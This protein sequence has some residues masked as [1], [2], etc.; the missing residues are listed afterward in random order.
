[1]GTPDFAVPTLE[2]LADSRHTV[3]AAVTNPDRPKGRGRK[4]AAPPVKERA[5]ALDIPVIQHNSVNDEQLHAELTALA[6]DLFVVVA[7][8]ILPKA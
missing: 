7:F 8:S 6:P 4:L 1:M 2:R 3:L 5:L